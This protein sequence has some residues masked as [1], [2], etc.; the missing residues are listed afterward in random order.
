MR[1]IPT[2][3]APRSKGGPSRVHL[4]AIALTTIHLRPARCAWSLAAAALAA[5]VVAGQSPAADPVAAKS[6]EP[7]TLTLEQVIQRQLSSFKARTGVYVKDLT[8]GEEAGVRADQ[9]FNSFSVIKLAI[10]VRAF[11]LADAGTLNLD[12]RVEVRRQDLRDG[13]GLLYAFDPGLRVTVRDLITQ[14]TITSDNTATD[15]MLTRVGGLQALNA[16]LQQA[17]FT[18]TR[19]VQSTLDFFRQ[20][21]VLRDPAYKTLS[22]EDVFAYYTHPTVINPRLMEAQSAR[23]EELQKAA[24][25][26]TFWPKVAGSDDPSYWLGSMT[27]R[28]TGRMLEAI[29]RGALASPDSTGQMKRILMEQREGRLRLPHYLEWP[30]YFVAHK[31]GDGP[32][33]IANDVGIVYGPNKRSVVISFFSAAIA[34]PYANHED[35]IGR[36]ARAVVD[37]LAAKAPPAK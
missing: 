10:M 37:Y 4:L 13:S 6:P 22:A 36:L 33:A 7:A 34:E 15:M 17:G 5:T 11:Q 31:T 23:G 35:R 12:E 14:M 8:T 26:A 3:L 19:M 16:W 18:S 1:S 29:E 27:A 9:A 20:A 32:P 24:P 21:L 28:E 25:I 30:D 2:A